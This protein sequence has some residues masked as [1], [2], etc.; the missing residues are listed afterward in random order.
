MKNAT[1]EK[2]RPEAFQAKKAFEKSFMG[3]REYGT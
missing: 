1:G 3:E 2:E